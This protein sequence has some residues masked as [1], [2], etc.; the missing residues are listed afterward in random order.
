MHR[1][2]N[3]EFSE[4][5]G[6]KIDNV[7][8]L[9]FDGVGKIKLGNNPHMLS[10]YNR[11]TIDLDP[12]ISE[13]QAAQKL[14]VMF[15]LLGLGAIAA[16]TR[17]IDQE[18]IKIMQ[19]FRAFYPKQAYPFEKN[20]ENYLISISE[21]RDKIN[22]A[23]PEMGSKFK[24]Y[25][26]DFPELMYQQE[27]YPGQTVWAVKGLADMVRRAGGIGLMAGLTAGSFT[28]AAERFCSILKWGALS[29]QDRF[30]LGMVVP[31]ASCKEDFAAGGADSVFARLLTND[32]DINPASFAL[33]GMMQILYDLNL[34]EQVGFCYPT[35]RFGS[36]DP[37][38][39]KDRG[40][41]VELAREGQARYLQ[42][43]EFCINRRI[44]P[45]YVKGAMIGDQMEKE[46]LIAA[47]EQHGLIT[48]NETHEKFCNGIPI[49]DFIH[50]G[51]FDETYWL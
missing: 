9:H 1:Q 4:K 49:D 33:C 50:I 30:Q 25:L 11:I 24:L 16:P 44:D 20:A 18:R 36:K 19:L 34:V 40:N 21:L 47:L 2:E 32:M 8:I 7:L 12:Q 39:Y 35:D 51:Y 28:Q 48:E 14:K 31:G 6:Y 3:G 13:E 22:A 43:N 38:R 37:S 29:T 26:D 42:D 41:I 17:E 10:E 15:A 5:E 27:V 23:V 46:E 45:R